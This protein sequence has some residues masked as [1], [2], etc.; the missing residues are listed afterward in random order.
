MYQVIKHVHLTSVALSLAGFLLRGFWMVT[1]SPLL[2]ARLTRVLPH[3]VDTVLLGSAL[4]LVSFYDSVPAW[5]WA[6]VI[7]LLCY[8]VLGTIALKRGRTLTIRLVA[9]GAALLTFA[10][11]VSVALTKQPA[12]FLA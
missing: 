7:G 4:A 11:I 8:I 10:W 2:K 3:V 12:G 1:G 5:V 9:M 6:K